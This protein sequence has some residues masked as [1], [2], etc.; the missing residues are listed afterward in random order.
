MYG[1]RGAQIAACVGA[2]APTV[3][4]AECSEPHRIRPAAKADY[5]A[6]SGTAKLGDVVDFPKIAG[7]I[8]LHCKVQLVHPSIAIMPV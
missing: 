8:K 6:P 1:Q 2:P 5:S 4:V 3:V 7:S